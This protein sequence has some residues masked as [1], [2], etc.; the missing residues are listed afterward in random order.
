MKYNI[1]ETISSDTVRPVIEALRQAENGQVILV[2]LPY[3]SGGSVHAA[4][5]LI[6]AIAVSQADVVIE[7]D[8]YVISAAA[9]IYCWFLV[10]KEDHVVVRTTG[11]N[12]LMIY[13]RPRLV[14]ADRY[15]GFIDDL[16]PDAG[17]DWEEL[18]FLTD[19]FDGVFDEILN[20]LEQNI[21]MDDA[22]LYNEK[23]QFRRDLLHAKDG[24]YANQDFVLPI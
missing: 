18:K 17:E 4:L 19:L 11:A 10:Y 6:T 5:D 21:V 23:Y 22:I 8:R 7:V 15:L 14:I 9:F 3:N 24:Y 2:H 20:A 16:D 12:A 13:H 1:S